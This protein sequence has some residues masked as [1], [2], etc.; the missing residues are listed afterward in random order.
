M[1][2][3]ATEIAILPLIAG[4]AIEQPDT[5]SGRIWHDTLDTIAQQD[6]YQ[7]LFWGRRIEKQ[8]D[9]VLLIGKIKTHTV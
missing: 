4:A 7:R 8:S 9:A 1:S 3:P 6:G 2:L 5:S